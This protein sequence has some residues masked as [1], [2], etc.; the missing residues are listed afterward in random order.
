MLRPPSPDDY[1]Q[2]ITPSVVHLCVQ[3]HGRDPAHRPG[4]SAIGANS[5][6]HQQL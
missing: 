3:P 2:F 6:I 4:L 5:V 1:H